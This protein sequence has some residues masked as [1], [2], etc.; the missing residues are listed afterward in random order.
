VSM[1]ASSNGHS[2]GSSSIIAGA[3]LG[4]LLEEWSLQAPLFY[5]SKRW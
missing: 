3:V 2:S 1:M 5:F 4:I